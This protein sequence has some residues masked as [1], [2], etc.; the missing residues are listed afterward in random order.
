MVQ[1]A[2]VQLPPALRATADPP[3]G[4]ARFRIEDLLLASPRDS[5]SR[6]TT[7]AVSVVAHIALIALVVLIPTLNPQTEWRRQWKTH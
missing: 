6:A 2:P 3:F 5:K 1:F 7:L 4:E